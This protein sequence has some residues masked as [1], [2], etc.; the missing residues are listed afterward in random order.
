MEEKV[1]ELERSWP[2]IQARALKQPSPGT[3]LLTDFFKL[4]IY[5][6]SELSSI[7]YIK[8]PKKLC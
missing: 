4:L 6:H 2:V 5:H 8:K 3:S 7:K 1:Q